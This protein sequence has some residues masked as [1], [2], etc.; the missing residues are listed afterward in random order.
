MT[1]RDALG[2]LAAAPAVPGRP[3]P[4]FVVRG[5]ASQL[6]LSS[7]KGKYP[8]LFFLFFTTCPHCQAATEVL[9]R[10][11][12]EYAKRGLRIVACAFDPNAEYTV[13]AF[14]QQYQTVFPTGFS[15]RAAVL[16][17]LNHPPNQP[18][19]VPIFVFIDK[20]GRIREQHMGSDPFFR[21]QE[22]NAR[23][24]IEALLKLQ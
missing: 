1:R 24:S 19:S 8:V 23:A 12:R 6:L 5:P 4:E 14:A 16:T 3:S 7:Y 2:L 22:K 9:N 10:L 21:A 18:L 13:A 20:K 17:Y 11:Q 15:S